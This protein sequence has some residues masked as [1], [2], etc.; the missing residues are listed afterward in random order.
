MLQTRARFLDKLNSVLY[1]F[2]FLSSKKVLNINFY[3]PPLKLVK[4]LIL[5]INKKK[6][7]GTKRIITF[8]LPLNYPNC[9]IVNNKLYTFFIFWNNYSIAFIIHIFPCISSQ[10]HL[11]LHKVCSLWWPGCMWGQHVVSMCGFI[12][13]KFLPA[14]LDLSF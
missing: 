13:I 6:N 7:C 11:F 8:F 9:V 3:I 14:V 4:C 1:L 12:K 5:F 2:F 10:L